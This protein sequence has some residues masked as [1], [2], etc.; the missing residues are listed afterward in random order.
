MQSFCY[1]SNSDTLTTGSV[2][3]WL[4]PHLWPWSIEINYLL[5]SQNLIKPSL[6]LSKV[7]TIFLFCCTA[8]CWTPALCSIGWMQVAR[9]NSTLWQLC[10]KQQHDI[11]QLP[12]FHTSWLTIKVVFFCLKQDFT[13]CKCDMIANR[14]QSLALPL[15]VSNTGPQNMKVAETIWLTVGNWWG[16]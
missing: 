10:H 9:R 14:T 15:F 12:Y 16:V 11:T 13:K 6:P 2:K 8:L 1:T 3:V 4:K 5:C 7:K